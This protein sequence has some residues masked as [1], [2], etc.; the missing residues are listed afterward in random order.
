MRKYLLN[1]YENFSKDNLE[2]FFDE[3]VYF[4]KDNQNSF[5]PYLSEPLLS[6][7]IKFKS[8]DFYIG[9]SDDMFDKGVD[10]YKNN[11]GNVDD[12]Q[13][14]RQVVSLLYSLSSYMLDKECPVCGQSNLRLVSSKDGHI[15]KFCEECLFT[16]VNGELTELK[17]ELYPAKKFQVIDY[18]NA[19]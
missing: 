4:I 18:V 3:L 10:F 8:K 13:I 7:I 17:D 12:E 9:K 5:D 6:E 2:K 14:A 11:V 16:S 1:I 19:H 15:Y